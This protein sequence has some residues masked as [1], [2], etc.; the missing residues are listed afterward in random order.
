MTRIWIATLTTLLLG[1]T[2][3]LAQSTPGHP[4]LGITSPLGVGLGAPVAPVHIPLGA[5]QMQ[6]IGV[7]PLTSGVSPVSPTSGTNSTC[8]GIGGSIPEASYGVA[9]SPA[10]TSS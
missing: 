8:G 3:A 10:G 6:S 5:T 2:S 1:C 9:S 4:P 7:S